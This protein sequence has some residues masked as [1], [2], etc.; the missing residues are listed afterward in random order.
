M[1]TI[2]SGDLSGETKRTQIALA[3]YETYQGVIK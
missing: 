2:S 1:L 3:V